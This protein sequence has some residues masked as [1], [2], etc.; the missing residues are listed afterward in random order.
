MYNTRIKQTIKIIKKITP[1]IIT[2]YNYYKI[3]RLFI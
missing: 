1:T 3:I 2:I